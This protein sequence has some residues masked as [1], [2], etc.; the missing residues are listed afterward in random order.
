MEDQ[1]IWLEASPDA[2]QL[3]IDGGHENY[4]EEPDGAAAVVLALVE[5]QD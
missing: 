1:A 5:R 3:E 2:H 4:L